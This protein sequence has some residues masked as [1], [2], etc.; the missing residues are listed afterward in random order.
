MRMHDILSAGVLLSAAT[1]GALQAYM[2]WQHHHPR[3]GSATTV[4]YLNNIV[5]CGY[6]AS[7]FA[8]ICQRQLLSY[9]HP[10]GVGSSSPIYAPADSGCALGWGS[11]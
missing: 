8:D 4:L 2:S 10:K 9:S 3:C 5:C 11:R 6:G 7:K 1:E